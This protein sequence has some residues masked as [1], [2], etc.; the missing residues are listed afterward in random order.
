MP[1]MLRTQQVEAVSAIVRGFDDTGSDSPWAHLEGL[2]NG[3]EVKL[4]VFLSNTWTR[5]AKLTAGKL[6]TQANLG[7]G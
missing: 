2:E 6:K 1:T 7:L 4:G 3:A 5:G